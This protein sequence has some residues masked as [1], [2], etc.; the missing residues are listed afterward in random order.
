[1]LWRV[2]CIVI[3][4]VLLLL[5]I[6]H[7]D[8]LQAPPGYDKVMNVG[9]DEIALSSSY[10]AALAAMSGDSVQKSQAALDA[11]WNTMALQQF[12]SQMSKAGV[13]WSPART[14]QD[15]QN[16]AVELHAPAF[17]VAG[18]GSGLS[19]IAYIIGNR[20]TPAQLTT[21]LP[22]G[23]GILYTLSPAK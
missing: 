20:A 7:D 8:H 15:A 2:V 11:L 13:R 10:S 19:G 23:T 14:L 6:W 16:R 12:T 21:A 18:T 9:L 4:L 17:G 1:M 5:L 3:M 22:T